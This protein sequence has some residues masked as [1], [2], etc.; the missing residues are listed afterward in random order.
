[1][2]IS[3]KKDLG[4]VVSANVIVMMVNVL[5]SFILPKWLSIDDYALFRTYTLYVSFIGILHFGFIDGLN[6]KFGG[7]ELKHIDKAY[8]TN[9]HRFFVIFQS[10]LAVVMVSTGILSGQFMLTLIGLA[11]IPIN[12]H[13]YSML[14]YQAVGKFTPYSLGLTLTPL[15]T[16]VLYIVLYYMGDFNYR[17]FALAHLGG[18]LIVVLLLEVYFHKNF[19]ASRLQFP[20]IRREE[21]KEIFSLGIFILAG[22]SLFIL[23]NTL[24]RWGIKLFMDNTAFAFYSFA[25]SMLGFIILAINSVALTLYPH[26]SKKGTKHSPNDLRSNFF[27]L[28]SFSLLFFFLVSFVVKTILPD[29]KESVS[30]LM[31]LLSSM[32]GLLIIKALYL[33]MY[34]VNQKTRKF[35]IDTVK[36]LLIAIVFHAVIFY[37]FRSAN[38]MAI[39]SVISIYIW[40]FS[41][42]DFL[43]ISTDQMLKEIVFIVICIAAYVLLAVLLHSIV[44]SFLSLIV[45]LIIINWLFYR[46]EFLHMIKKLSPWQPI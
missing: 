41:P 25:T 1:M 37:F 38:S 3:L 6:V 9:G 34:K 36:Y 5:I 10:L 23:F 35:F 39:A 20:K 15:I 30:I 43:K 4:K 40:V 11:I 44:I 19:G 7:V 32:P 29:Y 28:G 17:P 45:F 13:T 33:N 26:L 8:I 24:G 31:I 46:V 27:I 12:L 42:P 14:V 2:G 16:L 21:V 18:Y 22:N